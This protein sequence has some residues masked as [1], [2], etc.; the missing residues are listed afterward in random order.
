MNLPRFTVDNQIVGHMLTILIVVLGLMS[1]FSMNR[2]FFPKTEFDIVLVQT[3]YPGADPFQVEKH[4]TA[5]IEDEIRP[6]E[7]VD[8]Y[9]SRSM[10]GMSYVICE[11]DPDYPHRDRVINEINR[12]VSNIEDLPQDAEE[13][14]ISLV[15]MEDEVI[16]ILVSGQLPEYELRTYSEYLENM[17]ES[18]PNVSTVTREGWRQEEIWVE[19]DPVRLKDQQL[20]ILEVV[21]ILREANINSPGGKIYQ[22]GQELIIKTVSDFQNVEDVK[23]IFLRNNLSGKAVRLL[24]VADVK[25]SFNEDDNLFRANGHS[26]IQLLVTKNREGDLIRMADTISEIIEKE[27]LNA[28]EGV[29]LGTI[30]F[31]SYIVKRRLDVLVKNGLLGFV[32]VLIALPMLLNFR[33]AILT[34]IGIPFAFLAAFVLM[35]LFGVSINM[36]TMFALILVL[37]M[38]VDDAIIISENIY[39]HQE[40]GLSPKEAAVKGTKEVMWPVVTTIATTIA[41]FLP[42]VFMPGDMGKF[43]KWM[44]IVVILALIASLVE[45]LYVL[46]LHMSEFSGSSEKAAKRAKKRNSAGLFAGIQSIYLGVL[47]LVLKTRYVFMPLI[48]LLCVGSA[49]TVIKNRL[50]NVEMFPKDLIEVFT[51]NVTMDSGSSQADTESKVKELEDHIIE[52]AG[53]DL[54]NVIAYIGRGAVMSGN[55]GGRQG[56]QYAELVAY[57]IPDAERDRSARTIMD[58]IREKAADSN[59]TAIIEYELMNPGPPAE[60]DIEVKIKGAKSYDD[61]KVLADKVAAHLATIDGISDIASNYEGGKKE[62]RVVVDYSK[63]A[64]YQVPPDSV[65]RTVFAAFHGIE[66]TSIR[67]HDDD[68]PVRVMLKEPHRKEL[69]SLESLEV[70]NRVNRL[71]ALSRFAHI[72]DG[73]NVQLLAHDNGDRSINVRANLDKKVNDAFAVNDSLM[74]EFENYEE[75]HP[76]LVMERGGEWKEDHEMVNFMKKASAAALITIYGLLA[77]RFRSWRQPLILMSAIPFTMMGV[78]LILILHDLQISIMVMLGLVGLLGIIVNDSIVMVSFINDERK[79]NVDLYEAITAGGLKRLRPIILTSVTTVLGLL[80]V[81]YGI[82]GYEP[83]VAPA[84]LVIAYGLALA[85]VLTLIV[86]PCVYSIIES[87]LSFKVPVKSGEVKNLEEA[88]TN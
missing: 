10:Q 55:D 59:D 25:S 72:E 28:P 67:Q 8:S 88:Q 60:A 46:P 4:L 33:V 68:I 73:E 58:A 63:A 30:D 61:I 21:N 82:G 31:N 2:E 13:P 29:T 3:L 57:L 79:K 47:R 50:I 40:D 19:L 65:S 77:I 86:V 70:P 75:D 36:L 23:K 49:Y 43:M 87:P 6:I 64:Q 52:V 37:G 48:I 53:D 56:N 32:L 76:G 26:A 81:I 1:V 15:T 20:S 17:I 16:R 42:M 80:P 7:G 27:K 69:S 34:A 11:L 18:V 71:I 78:V 45:A 38:I 12:K 39:R 84:A 83:F 74:K 35:D 51:V 24:D 85:T 66:A 54:E 5:R 41:A 62:K 44:P 14:D 9:V 22:D